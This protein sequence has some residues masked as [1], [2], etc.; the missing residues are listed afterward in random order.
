[1][2]ISTGFTVLSGCRGFAIPLK[3]VVGCVAG[4]GVG[5][6]VCNPPVT[7][8]VGRAPTDEIF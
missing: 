3:V 5:C 1:M 4:L 8:V 6:V 7:V 2:L